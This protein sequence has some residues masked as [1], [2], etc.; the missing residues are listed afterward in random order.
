MFNLLVTSEEGAWAGK[1]YSMPIDRCVRV[2]E[3]T[4]K[5]IAER[6]GTFSA[7]AMVS[8]LNT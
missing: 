8:T 6:L 1:I 2:N 4:P 5:A 7:K 3:Y